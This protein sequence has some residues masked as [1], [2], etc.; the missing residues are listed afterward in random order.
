[1]V[2]ASGVDYLTHRGWKPVPLS[3]AVKRCLNQVCGSER[4]F[5][6]TFDDGYS[7]VYERGYPLLCARGI[8]AT[9][10]VVAGAVGGTNEWDRMA[11]DR[12]E[13]MMSAAQLREIAENGFEIGSHT[14]THARLTQLSADRLRQ[15][16]T[17]SKHKLEDI[18]GQEVVSCSY[19]YGDYNSRVLEACAS[20]GYRYGVT[21][22][23][24]IVSSQTRAYE[25]PR[26]NVRWNAVGPLLARK[27][28]RAEGPSE[29]K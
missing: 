20:A 12:Q 27:I 14:M 11:G 17:D 15:E 19:P 18:I 23:L 28:R 29:A 21:T 24:G 9:V 16:L 3:E 1:L 4:L 13:K 7:S 6:I 8:R 26:V 22:R 5:S 2:L 25:I 10:Y